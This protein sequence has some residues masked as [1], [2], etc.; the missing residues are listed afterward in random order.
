MMAKPLT[1]WIK[2]ASDCQFPVLAASQRRLLELLD[3]EENIKVEDILNIARLDPGFSISLLREA[4]IR[5]KKKREITTL[6]H[7]ILL[8]SIPATI[9]LLHRSPVLEQTVEPKLA[10]KIKRLYFYQHLTGSLAMAWSMQRQ[11]SETNELF[12]AGV[13]RDFLH[14]FLYL[15]DIDT[16]IQLYNYSTSSLSE[17]LEK[18]REVLGE[19]MEELSRAIAQAW[20]LPYLIRESFAEQRHNPKLEGIRLASELVQWL[21]I[22]KSYDYPEKLFQKVTA[23]LRVKEN[24]THVLINRKMV[25]AFRHTHGKLPAGNSI[26]AFMSHPTPLIEDKKSQPA[27]RKQKLKNCIEMLRT[28]PVSASTVMPIRQAIN[29]L[30]ETIGFTRTAFFF[31]NPNEKCLDSPVTANDSASKR[32][33]NILISLELN[34]L[35]GRL[36]QKEVLLVIN[37]ANKHKYMPHLPPALLSDNANG[38]MLLHSMNVSGDPFGC[39][40][41]IMDDRDALSEAELHAFKTVCKE[42]KSALATL[43]S[44]HNSQVA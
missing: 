7:A 15:T 10:Y 33:R 34:K 8:L 5:S 19:S 35:F 42:L 36:M 41:I 27:S 3:N 26:R 6:S 44:G 38:T 29:T 23:Y 11:E 12:T 31:M 21:Y 4:G 39:F 20:H 13:N 2:Q 30:H 14:F 40:I 16:A 1:E 22:H 25:D 37:E 24:K 28:L 18:E 17:L 32:L 9:K 43:K